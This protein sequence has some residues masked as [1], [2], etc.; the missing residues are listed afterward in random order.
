MLLFNLLREY[1]LRTYKA[2]IRPTV[3][4]A[5]GTWVVNKMKEKA[6]ERWESKILRSIFARKKTENA[7]ER[8]TNREL[9]S[10]FNE[11]Y[12]GSDD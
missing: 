4:Y 1:K 7:Q 2:V 6:L 5:Y 12:K 8:R 11:Q 9:I 10:L 3:T